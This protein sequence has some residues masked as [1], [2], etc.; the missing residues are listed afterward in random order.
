MSNTR[1]SGKSEAAGRVAR[2][3]LLVGLAFAWLVEPAGPAAPLR[4]RGRDLP[5]LCPIR[6]LTGHRC[7]GC[8]MTR[9]VVYLLRLRVREALRANPLSPLALAFVVAT[10]LGVGGRRRSE[11]CMPSA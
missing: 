9:G 6:R 11:S 5:V 4:L 1:S 3:G 2:L 10:A 7:P 8:G